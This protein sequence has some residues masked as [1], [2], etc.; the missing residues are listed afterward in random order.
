MLPSRKALVKEYDVDLRTIQRA[1][2]DLLT[3][4]TL[5]AH[6]GRGTFVGLSRDG[7]V[8]G[9]SSV[10]VRTVVIIA[11]PSFN[12]GPSWPVIVTAIHEE[13]RRQIENCRILTILTTDKFPEGVITHE[14]DALR[15]AHIENVAGVIMF[16]SGGQATLADIHHVIAAKIPVVFVDRI[17]FEH[18]CNFVGIDNRMAAREA[19][20]Y[21]ISQG[22]RRIAFLAPSEDISSVKERLEGY[23][24]ACRHAGLALTNDLVFPLSLDKLF[25]NHAIKSEIDRVIGEIMRLPEVPTAIFA[26]N[27]FLAEYLLTALEEKGIAVPDTLSVIG[28]D[29]MAR[30]TPQKPKLTTIRQ[31]FESIG[32]RAASMLAWRI[33]HHEPPLPY[34]HVLLPTRLVVRESTKNIL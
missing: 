21:L 10:A 31:P 30:F 18:G 32:E 4:G 28:F 14:K 13:L 17:P 26:V 19:T 12:P 5:N 8:G 34:Q 16:H 15:L 27:D 3:D 20:E 2:S 29:D 33:G 24:D 25:T 11:D 6:G 1:I 7:G 9:L 23:F 22:H